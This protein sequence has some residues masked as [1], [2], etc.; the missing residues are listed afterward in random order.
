MRSGDTSMQQRTG[1]P[2]ADS[3]TL[4][5]TKR[6]A[7]EWCPVAI[8]TLAHPFK[9]PPHRP[10][11]LCRLRCFG[12]NDYGQLDAPEV[13]PGLNPGKAGSEFCPADEHDYCFN[14]DSGFRNI[15]SGWLHTCGITADG[16]LYCWGNNRQGQVGRDDLVEGG[17]KCSNDR[18]DNKDHCLAKFKGKWALLGD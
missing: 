10:F 8:P 11:L 2:T 16:T 3:T 17:I 5:Q 14:Y 6:L 12:A 13:W 7:S 15:S 18:G 4:T 9:G 1:F